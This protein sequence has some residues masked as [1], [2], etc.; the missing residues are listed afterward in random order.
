MKTRARGSVLG[1]RPSIEAA[2][3]RLGG[4]ISPD[5]APP[6]GLAHGLVV[7]V[8]GGRN[9]IVP[10]VVVFA[11]RSEVHVLL[12]GVRLRRV[13][14]DH[15][16]TYTGDVSLALSKIAGDAQLF[17]RLAEGEAVRY[18]G[19]DGTLVQAKVVE[20]CRWGA[21]VAR[22]DGAVIAVGFRKL[23]PLSAGGEV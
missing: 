3:Q 8:A 11:S 10:G 19:D 20:K 17:A 7:G 12:D 9:T 15:V 1:K 2:R 4:R 21:L 22:D 14:P 6:Q 18:A 23:W 13:L 5:D 16:R